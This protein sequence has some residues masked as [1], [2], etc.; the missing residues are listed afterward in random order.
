MYT[1]YYNG[2][3]VSRPVPKAGSFEVPTYP[4]PE[5][6]YGPVQNERTK[7][8]D[9]STK[10]TRATAYV[11]RVHSALYD[12]R[13]FFLYQ[14]A[15]IRKRYSEATLYN[16]TRIVVNY[17]KKLKIISVVLPVCVGR[18]SEVQTRPR[19]RLKQTV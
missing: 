16:N 9:N 6:H 12:Q 17:H 8:T 18:S 7:I 13:F 1:F 2:Y 3:V 11:T 19:S 5:K 4:T 14:F 10:M 15:F